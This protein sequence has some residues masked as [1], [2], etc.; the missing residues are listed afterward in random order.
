MR[1]VGWI[2]AGML[3]LGAISVVWAA[4]SANKVGG[5]YLVYPGAKQGPVVF[6]HLAHINGA[7]FK[8]GDCHPAMKMKRG[9]VTMDDINAGKACGQCHNGKTVG[10]KSGGTAFAATEC[11]G[12]HMPDKDLVFPAAK[13][14]GK[15]TFAHSM[16]TGAV[17]GD[18]IVENAGF[19]CGECH[20]KVFKAKEGEPLGMVVPHKTGA[21][22][23]CHDGQKTSPSG[24][25]AKTALG[26]CMMC[27]KRG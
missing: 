3:A 25:V 23:T 16:H 8:C 1:L 11:T 12:C 26:N 10:P 22:A 20:P 9:N 17:D 18:K 2:G 27:H 7:G 21:C 24:M 19:A 15:V 4:D 5:G 6:S 13:G 14:P